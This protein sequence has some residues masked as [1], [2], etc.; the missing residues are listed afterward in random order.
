[1]NMINLLAKDIMNRDVLSVGMDWSIEQLANYLIEKGISGAPVTSED[2]KLLGVVSMT[3]IV[4]YRSMPITDTSKDDPHEY[5][6]YPSEYHYK[7]SEIESFHIDAQS[8]VTVQ[9]IMT[10]MTFNVS[11]D[12]S[13]QKVADAMLRGRIHRVFVTHDGVLVGI[14]TTMDMLAAIREI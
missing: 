12:T 6:M 8:L 7:P 9:D 4:R 13:L 10:P 11:E 2:G 14:I 3:D 5:Y 1:M